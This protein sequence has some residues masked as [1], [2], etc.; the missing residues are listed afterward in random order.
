MLMAHRACLPRVPG[1][2]KVSTSNKTLFEPLSL[3]L[4]DG[5]F[6]M[7][8]SHPARVE[9]RGI[10]FFFPTVINMTLVPRLAS[11]LKET[12][13]CTILGGHHS[14]VPGPRPTDRWAG[15]S[16]TTLWRF[17]KQ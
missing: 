11:P 1:G 6:C 7:S 10:L 9:S 15:D 16:G 12:M 17:I 3:G 2:V 14:R 4:P 8:G 5:N 13:A